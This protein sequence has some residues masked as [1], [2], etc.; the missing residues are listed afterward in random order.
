ME[1]GPRIVPLLAGAVPVCIAFNR[2][3]R[4]FSFQP[5]G[6]RFHLCEETKKMGGSATSSLTGQPL[7][8]RSFASVGVSAS[9]PVADMD[10]RGPLAEL[11]QRIKR[12]D[13]KHIVF[14]VGAGISVAAG[15]PDFRSPG[16]G[17][18]DNLEKY[19]LP[20]P[21]AIFD[22]DYFEERPE[23]FC[24]L[25]RELWPGQGHIKPTTSH[26]FMRLL[27]DRGILARVYTQNID[28]LEREAGVDEK[29]LVEAHGSF[30]EASCIRCR[31]QHTLEWVRQQ[32]FDDSI[33]VPRCECG[34]LVKPNIVFFGEDLPL[35]F[36]QCLQQDFGRGASPDLVIVAGTSLQVHPF[37]SIPGMARCPRILINRELPETFMPRSWDVTM[38]GDCDAGFS[39]LAGLLGWKDDLERLASPRPLSK[40]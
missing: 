30:H 9:Q 4:L 5:W 16:T 33:K 32:I 26:H 14:C 21:E 2:T 34:G 18:Y 24:T 27:Q 22:L 37:A 31:K 17:L 1:R 40:L 20:H 8:P 29:L 12:G 35:R 3:S 39:H 11:I 36:G 28:T 6:R 19:K 38:L 23:A 13:Y 10:I 25:A 7:A 15:I